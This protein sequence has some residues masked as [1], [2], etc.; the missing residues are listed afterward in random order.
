MK[1]SGVTLLE[2]LVTLTILTI[3]ATVAL[4]FTKVSTKRTKEIELRQNLR[5]IRA[6][7]L[8]EILGCIVGSQA[9]GGA[10]D[11][12]RDDDQ[13]IPAIDSL[14]SRDRSRRLAPALLPRS[15]Q[16]EG[17]VRRRC[18]RCYDS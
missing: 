6:L 1:Q 16:C 11:G 3:L 10:G 7:W 8:P 17:L 12:A 4:P 15:R 14:G 13:A 9:D 2:L 5:V 18:V